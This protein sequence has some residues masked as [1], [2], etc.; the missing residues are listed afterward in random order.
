[1]KRLAFLFAFTFIVVSA[2]AGVIFEDD[3]EDGTLDKWT[4]DGR[5]EGTNIAEVVI[6]Y[7]SNMA[8]LRHEGFTEITLEKVF[9]YSQYLTFEFDMEAQVSS[10]Y[11]PTSDHY[12][13]SGVMFDFLDEDSIVLARAVI[14]RSS[15]SYLFSHY[16]PL[17]EWEIFEIQDDLLHSYIVNASDILSYFDI[18]ESLVGYLNFRFWAYGSALQDSLEADVWADNVR[19]TPEPCTLILLAAGTAVVLRRKSC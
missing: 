7:N 1:M 18:D 5:Q 4:I 6:K 3:F 15:S 14:A 19:V 2:R 11:G 17:P 16:N 8:H 10:P 12:S 9:D 13:A